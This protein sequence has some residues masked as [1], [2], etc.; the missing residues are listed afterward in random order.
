MRLHVDA[1]ALVELPYVFTQDDVLNTEQF[2]RRADEWGV[3]VDDAILRAL[4]ESRHL[5]PL[6]R[7]SD[8]AVAGRARTVP[9]H[10]P[11]MSPRATVLDAAADGRLRD[12]ALEGY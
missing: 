1:L 8:D 7:V 12:P 9:A 11:A 2:A 6:Y 3:R 4:H 10:V 5:L